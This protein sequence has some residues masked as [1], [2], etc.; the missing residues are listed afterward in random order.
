MKAS[1]FSID[2]TVLPRPYVKKQGPT[3][4]WA[5]VSPNPTS[6]KVRCPLINRRPHDHGFALQA[7]DYG[8]NP[9]SHKMGY[10][11]WILDIINL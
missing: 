11:T 3:R 10:L 4:H 8:K 6:P 9:T 1:S 2:F 7:E 5:V